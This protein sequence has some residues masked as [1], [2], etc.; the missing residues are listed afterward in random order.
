MDIQSSGKIIK[1]VAFVELC[2][3]VAASLVYC[4]ICMANELVG[5]GFVV[6]LC[7]SLGSC[8]TAL[9]LYGFG[10]IVYNS[11][12]L[13]HLQQKNNNKITKLVNVNKN[14]GDEVKSPLA[15]E[16]VTVDGKD[17]TDYYLIAKQKVE[18]LTDKKR[19]SIIQK[20][21][22]WAKNITCSTIK[23]LCETLDE[24]DEWDDDFVRLTCLEIVFRAE[25]K[26]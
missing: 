26:K 18:D 16:D 8:L 24:I 13:V 25:N 15:V 4:I 12:L 19:D 22:D 6:L 11:D 21:R 20:H 7:G 1:I 9:F 3:G 2:L 17:I 10:Q 23:D 5:T 14:Q